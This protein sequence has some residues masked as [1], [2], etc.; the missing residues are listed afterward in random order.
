[1]TPQ[2]SPARTWRYRRERCVLIG[3]RCQKCGK[4]YY[5]PRRRCECG[6]GLEEVKLPNTGTL[7]SYT[8]TYNVPE[9]F[10]EQSPLIIGIVEL[11]NG[12]R[13]LAPITDVALEE[14][15]VGMELEATLRR[16]SEDGETGLIRYGVK[17]RPRIG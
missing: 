11:D 14:L 9:G 10:R 8:V 1:M 2:I 7:L 6:G 15:K 13:V 17:F 16:I 3:S 4:T 12:V 5:P